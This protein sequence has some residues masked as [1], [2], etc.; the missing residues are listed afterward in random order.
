[1]PSTSIPFCGT[2]IVTLVW[3]RSLLGS[4]L[5]TPWERRP[6]DR[7]VACGRDRRH[8]GDRQSSPR[9][10]DNT[11]EQGARAAPTVA[12]SWVLSSRCGSALVSDVWLEIGPGAY[13]SGRSD[14]HAPACGDG[15]RG[16]MGRARGAGTSPLT[17]H[18]V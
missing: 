7:P 3:L 10:S 15:E 18:R 17:G 5:S 9:A 6:E 1:M 2:F 14:V 4:R 12:R 13:P 11:H 8:G 16:G